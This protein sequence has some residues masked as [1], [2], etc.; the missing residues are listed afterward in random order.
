MYRICVL[1][2][3][4]CC[5]LLAHQRAD[6]R[7]D[8]V[9]TSDL[10]RFDGVTHVLA[11]PLGEEIDPDFFVS[12]LTEAIYNGRNHIAEMQLAPGF[13]SQTLV[14]RSL[15][16]TG[17]LPVVAAIELPSGEFRNFIITLDEHGEGAITLDGK[18]RELRDTSSFKQGQSFKVRLASGMAFAA[19]LELA[20]KRESLTIMA[21]VQNEAQAKATVTNPDECLGYFTNTDVPIMI[22]SVVAYATLGTLFATTY[23]PSSGFVTENSYVSLVVDYPLAGTIYH[24]PDGATNGQWV[25]NVYNNYEACLKVAYAMKT[26]TT[27]SAACQDSNG[28]NLLQKHTWNNIWNVMNGTGTGSIEATYGCQSGGT[29]TLTPVP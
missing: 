27:A 14:L 23:D 12:D 3:F 4:T 18:L 5:S 8:A 22:N 21:P 17:G 29:W 26:K 15:D 6:H 7:W 19:D 20:D 10:D 11:G 9:E 1:L 13:D 25:S 2:F 28:N 16:G 24:R